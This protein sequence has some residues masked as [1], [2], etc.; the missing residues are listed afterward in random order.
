MAGLA[1]LIR[2]AE[3]RAQQA[4]VEWQ[5]LAA[6]CRDAR[7]KLERLQQH[8]QAYREL[9]HK[10]LKDGMPAAA[11]VGHIGFIAQIEAVAARQQSELAE[12]EGACAQHHQAVVNAR[13]E[14]RIY[15]LLS[16]QRKARAANAE[17]RRQHLETGELLQRALRDPRR[18]LS[19]Q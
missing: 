19:D 1:T 5:R 18:V 11:S 3:R 7:D 13:R 14:Q 15:E 8:R 12:L 16:E 6:R 2:L 4:V 17:T 10:R 9:M